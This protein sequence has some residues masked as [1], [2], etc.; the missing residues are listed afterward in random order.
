M[1][2][3]IYRLDF[4]IELLTGLHIGGST[5][6][7]DI[8]GADSTVIKNPLTHEPYIPGSSIKGKLRSLL[9]QKYG[10]V[11]VKNKDS[12]IVLERDEIRC[13]FEPVSTSDELKVSRCILEM[14]T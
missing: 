14:H 1:L 7:F 3:C 13:L 10:K 11:S 6:T 9:T 4:E 8:G 12:E 2:E 5:D